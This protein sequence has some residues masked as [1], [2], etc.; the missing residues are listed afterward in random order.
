MKFSFF[1]LLL[2]FPFNHALLIFLQNPLAVPISVVAIIHGKRC[3]GVSQYGGA[4]G[5]GLEQFIFLMAHCG[6]CVV[7][8]LMVLSRPSG[9]K[10]TI[11]IPNPQRV[12]MLPFCLVEYI[13]AMR[14]Q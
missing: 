2:A 4:S 3:E 13:R 6:E 11:I 8:I 9:R 5:N 12:I 14:P 10:C 7:E 1:I